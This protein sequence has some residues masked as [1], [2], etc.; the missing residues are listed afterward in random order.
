MARH[1]DPTG[2]ALGVPEQVTEDGKKARQGPK[3]A[4][5]PI[6]L[7]VK[8]LSLRCPKGGVKKK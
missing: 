6:N 5:H 4:H 7:G 2:T 8:S 3:P 1:E